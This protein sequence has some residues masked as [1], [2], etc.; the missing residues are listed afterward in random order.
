VG[1]VAAAGAAVV[2]VCANAGTAPTI[3]A[4]AKR[5]EY[6][7]FINLLLRVK[8]TAKPSLGVDGRAVKNV[9]LTYGY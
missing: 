9:G 2:G 6:K 4:A 1:P 5:L 7:A 8:G 3:V